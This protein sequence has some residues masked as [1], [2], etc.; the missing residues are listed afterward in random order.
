LEQTG[1]EQR[2]L[3]R[4]VV[5]HS[6]WK[7]GELQISMREPFESLRLAPQTA[8]T[9]NSG[10]VDHGPPTGTPNV[11]EIRQSSRE[12]DSVPLS[13]SGTTAD[14]AWSSEENSGVR[15]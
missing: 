3:L 13:K 10:P 14:A 8:T 12:G 11:M 7:K 15:E 9:E 2:K 6:S 5:Q 4:A 1:T